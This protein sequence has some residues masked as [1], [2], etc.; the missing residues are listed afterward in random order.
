MNQLG[1]VEAYLIIRYRRKKIQAYV[2][3]GSSN[4]A[5]QCCRVPRIRVRLPSVQRFQGFVSSGVLGKRR[6]S[7]DEGFFL[8]TLHMRGSSVRRLHENLYFHQDD[9]ISI[10]SLC[11]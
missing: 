6:R 10:I 5:V 9:R 4:A 7:N 3:V 11:S 1:N 8:N 2:C